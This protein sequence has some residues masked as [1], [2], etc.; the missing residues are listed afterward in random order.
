MEKRGEGTT[1]SRRCLVTALVLGLTVTGFVH[2]NGQG[3]AE[4]LVAPEEFEQRTGS[5]NP[6]S[7]ARGFQPEGALP[8]AAFGDV[9][10]DGDVDLVPGEV[11]LET[12][13]GRLSYYENAGAPNA[14]DFVR[15]AA[16]HPLAGPVATIASPARG[17]R[18]FGTND[19]GPQFV[20]LFRNDGAPDAPDLT[21]DGRPD[22]V[23]VGPALD[24][25]I[26]YYPNAGG[27]TARRSA[28][29]W[30]PPTATRI[31]STT[32]VIS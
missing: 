6:L 29:P 1:S 18:G 16:S 2:A 27:A 7:A 14:P 23:N 30:L 3:E 25:W 4:P 9:D 15:Q 31:R 20:L 10:G 26:H 13:T 5:G 17:H 28:R 24:S 22:M 11:D 19:E 8:Y 12:R 21:G 32:S